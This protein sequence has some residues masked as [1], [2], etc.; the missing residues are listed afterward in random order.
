[1]L[2]A[3]ASDERDAATSSRWLAS[4]GGSPRS[5]SLIARASQHAQLLALVARHRDELRDVVVGGRGHELGRRRELAQLA[6]MHHRDPVREHQRLDH[7]V[8]DHDRVSPSSRW[9][10]AQLVLERDAGDRIERA[11]RLVEQQHARA[12]RERARDADALALA[13]RQLVGKP[14]AIRRRRQAR[15]ASSSSSTRAAISSARP[16]E[17]PR[18][19]RDVVGDREVR[20]Q[21]DLLDHVADRAA[22]RDRILAAHVAAVDL[23]PCPR[24]AR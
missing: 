8:G 18:H 21:P 2:I 17:Q 7:V 23:G 12:R 15:P 22:Q 24:R 14:L 19:H 11:E 13:A 1:M 9:I 4:S 3:T 10:R 16:A 6:A 20:K 5:S